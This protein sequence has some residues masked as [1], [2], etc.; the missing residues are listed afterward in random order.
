MSPIMKYSLL[1]LIAL[2]LFGLPDRAVADYLGGITFDHAMGSYLPNGEYVTLS[3]DYK[4]DEAS[5][6]RI[7][8]LPFTNGA[9]TPNYAVSGS[10]IYGPGTG[11]CTPHMTITSGS[12]VIDHVRVKLVSPDQSETWLEFFL[13]VSFIYGPN[14]VY[15]PTPSHSKYSRLR[16]GQQFSV[17]FDYACS[18]A[19]G[20]YAFARPYTN[21]HLTPGYSASGSALL[22]P[23]GSATQSFSFANDADVDHIWFYLRDHTNTTILFECFVAYDL[24]WR[25][26]GVYDISFNWDRLSSLHNTQNL[27]AT[28][29]LD[30]TEP[31]GLRAWAW[32]TTDGYYS[33]G[34]VY[35]GSILEPSGAHVITR[36]SRIDSGETDVDG[37]EFIVGT[38]TEAYLD[39]IV[40]V[41][42]HYA[43]H[44][45]Q[46]HQFSPAAPAM[47]SNGEHL[48]MQF[49]YVT[50]SV[51]PVLIFARPAYEENP[52]FGITS[53]GSPHYSPPS[54]SGTFW[55]TFASGDYLANSM[56]FQ[57]VD[58]SQT[59][60]HL[61]RFVPG[62]WA[63]G[64]STYIS[65]VP[66]AIP[67]AVTSLG[68]AYPNPFNPVATIP[69]SLAADMAVRLAVYDLRGRLVRTLQDGV[70]TAGD[71][72]F[73]FNGEGLASGTYFCR[74]ETPAGVQTKRMTLVK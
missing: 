16:H 34:G 26:I 2:A 18:D 27:V 11:T 4:I 58:M 39:F 7:F 67:A 41:D 50:S 70:L 49:D 24:H 40:P 14:G 35:E 22:P 3:I 72:A 59:I 43:P 47:L 60:L 21:G 69:V 55:L 57:M 12:V 1:L 29:T 73:R 8:I 28:F 17:S 51:D 31:A 6:G 45:M 25:A 20:C 62:L 19:A 53:S 64:G 71:H 15:D 48:N 23:S 44:A 33:P 66:E 61:E 42:Y 52:L 68:P 38:P 37:V 32:C 30:H 54:G 9:W 10:P 13:P 36:Y 5:G 56:R 46:N 74:L 63:W 65:P